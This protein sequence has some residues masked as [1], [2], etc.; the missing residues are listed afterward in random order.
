MKIRWDDEPIKRD[1][2]SEGKGG[3]SLFAKRPGK[4]VKQMTE[5]NKLVIAWQPYSTT[6]KAAAFDLATYRKD[7]NKMIEFCGF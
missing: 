6:E 3:D 4:F 7:L 5:K 1:L 2:W